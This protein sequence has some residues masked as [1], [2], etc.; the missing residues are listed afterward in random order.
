M[1]LAEVLV[2]ALRGVEG[3]ERF[4]GSRGGGLDLLVGG[5][6]EG[7][8]HFGGFAEGADAAAV[9]GADDE[10]AD[11]CAEDVAEGCVSEGFGER[12][13]CAIEGC[14]TGLGRVWGRDVPVFG[15]D[16]VLDEFDHCEGCRI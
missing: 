16:E 7:V 15:G 12:C 6:F 9:P 3:E 4:F 10:G 14:G 1:V 2:R 8:G 5:V 11:D 13:A